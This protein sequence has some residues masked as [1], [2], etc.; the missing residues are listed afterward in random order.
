VLAWWGAENT[1]TFCNRCLLILLFHLLVINHFIRENFVSLYQDW[2]N[3]G[4]ESCL[5]WPAGG[6]MFIQILLFAS[7]Q[8]AFLRYAEYIF[9]C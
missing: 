9:A 4:P 6:S 7:K 8:Q 2:K 5:M 1:P 3:R